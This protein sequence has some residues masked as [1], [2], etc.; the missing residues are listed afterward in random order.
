MTSEHVGCVVGQKLQIAGG[1][2]TVAPLRCM[3]FDD[4]KGDRDGEHRITEG[5][6]TIRLAFRSFVGWI[7]H[8]AATRDDRVR[9]LSAT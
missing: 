2:I 3:Q 6:K 4:G 5:L 8:C 1:E 7:G 9:A